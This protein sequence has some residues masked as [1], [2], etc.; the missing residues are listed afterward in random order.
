MPTPNLHVVLVAGVIVSA[1]GD[2][3]VIA[4]PTDVLPGSEVAAIVAGPAIYLLAHALI[5]LRMTGSMS[6]KRLLGALACLAAGIVGLF[7]P[8][9]VLAALL[10]AVLVAVIGSEYAAAA[11]RRARGEPSPLESLETSAAGRGRRS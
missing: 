11:R 4:H 10:I 3:L 8:A 1:V 9:L 7:V 2:E 5:R 6:R